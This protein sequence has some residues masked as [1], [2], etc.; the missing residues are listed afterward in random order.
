MVAEQSAAGTLRASRLRAL[1]DLLPQ[2]G[3]S[4]DKVLAAAGLSRE[5]L[6]GPKGMRV[7]ARAEHRLWQAIE[8]E[9]GDSTIGLRA[10]ELYLQ[11]GMPS[12]EGYLARNSSTVRSA[13]ADTDRFAR[14]SDDR[15]RMVLL[16]DGDSA[17]IRMLRDPAPDRAQGY[18]ECHFAIMIGFVQK[19]VGP[20]PLWKVHLRRPKPSNLAAYRR[21]FNGV[22]PT[23]DQPY[24]EL[25]F[26]RTSL[27]QPI[28][29]A[30]PA[31]A[32][33]L[34]EH[35]Q[36]L[37]AH[38]PSDDP[39][40]SRVR[41]ALTRGVQHGRINFT[42]ITTSLAVS[43]RTLRRQLLERQTSYQALVDE[44]RCEFACKLLMEDVAVQD[45]A[46]R[47]GFRS[48]SAFQ[49]AFARWMNVSPSEYRRGRRRGGR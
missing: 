45:V 49:K 44:V 25:H 35:A 33:I 27:D 48:T 7:H 42:Q 14:I 24:N 29:G 46:D 26:P 16:E 9:A 28:R 37:A 4:A 1:V 23:F 31:L 30:E 39:L 20:L 5:A 43:E 38:V 6:S 22:L 19:Y 18:V 17:T 47:I 3:V 21:A 15:L 34:A 32:H 13:L 12:I 40:I 11:A 36:H 8:V 2:L 10:A 41:A